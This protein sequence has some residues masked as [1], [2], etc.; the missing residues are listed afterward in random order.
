[1]IP[2]TGHGTNSPRCS[3]VFFLAPLVLA[4]ALAACSKDS[5]DEAHALCDG[6][7]GVGMRVEGRAA[8]LEVCVSD[9]DVSA[10]LTAL[11]RYD[12]SAQMQT[13]DGIFQ[14]RMVFAQRSDF[15]VSLRIV[16][17]IAEVSS[18]PGTAFV[19]YE[20]IP[21]GGK[22]IESAAVSGGTF[23]LSFSDDKIAAGFFENVD[24]SM[25]EVLTGDPAGSRRLVRGEFSISVEAPAASPALLP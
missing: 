12:V 10:L 16:D 1:M 23:R 21:E 17:S 3:H 9:A 8:P 19:Y 5:P 20:E 14:V 24:M 25:K 13:D 22:P 7:F 2:Q 15:P 4:A 11:S 6:D 18:D